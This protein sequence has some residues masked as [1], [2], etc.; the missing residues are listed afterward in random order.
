MMMILFIKITS[1]VVNDFRF[2]VKGGRESS[3]DFTV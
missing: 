3:E 2:A 1:N